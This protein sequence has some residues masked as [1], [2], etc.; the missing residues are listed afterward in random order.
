MKIDFFIMKHGHVPFGLDYKNFVLK[1]KYFLTKKEDFFLI[2][3]L[4]Y[5]L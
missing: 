1:I 2:I 3:A 5:F 4:Y